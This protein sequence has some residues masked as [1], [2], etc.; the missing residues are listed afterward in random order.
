M[1]ICIPKYWYTLFC[2]E[3]IFVANSLT[4]LAYL[5][6]GL[7]IWWCTKN[8]NYQVCIFLSA[9]AFA[10]MNVLL[11]LNSFVCPCLALLDSEPHRVARFSFPDTGWSNLMWCICGIVKLWLWKCGWWSWQ[12]WWPFWWWGW[13]AGCS[14]RRSQWSVFSKSWTV[15]NGLPS[16][17][18]S[19]SHHATNG[20][21]QLMQQWMF[22]CQSTPTTPQRSLHRTC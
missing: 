3:T 13:C 5:F 21:T 2:R 10:E 11:L 20:Q 22:T 7:K 16:P 19:P 4:F 17:S 15:S 14:S 18:S 12:R 8:D 1:W 9:F 6:S